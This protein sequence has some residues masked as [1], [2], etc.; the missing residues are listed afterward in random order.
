MKKTKQILAIITIAFL[1]LL[2]IGSL[3]LALIGS[4]TA[5]LLLKIALAMSLI[6]PTLIYGLLLFHKLQK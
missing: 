5:I 6:I 2:Y 1:V 3:I 4:S